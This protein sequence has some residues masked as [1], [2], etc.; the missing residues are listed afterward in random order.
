MARHQLSKT[1]RRTEKTS[2][3]SVL[4]VG[5]LELTPGAQHPEAFSRL[6]PIMIAISSSHYRHPASIRPHGVAI[7]EDG[8]HW[9]ANCKK[10]VVQLAD[11][12]VQNARPTPSSSFLLTPILWRWRCLEANGRRYPCCNTCSKLQATSTNLVKC[13]NA[14]RV[15]V[16]L[17]STCQNSKGCCEDG[18]VYRIGNN[19]PNGRDTSAYLPADH[20]MP[21]SSLWFPSPEANRSLESVDLV[22]SVDITGMANSHCPRTHLSDECKAVAQSFCR[23]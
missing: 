1:W 4:F 2:T 7:D 18:V 21:V 22:L 16:F 11:A 23:S 15:D 9:K 20:P 3:E 14:M 5:N 6:V 13:I 12:L 8:V 19:P 10:A 17:A